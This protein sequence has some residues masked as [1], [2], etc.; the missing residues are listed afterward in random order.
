[1]L[2]REAK[3][4]KGRLQTIT[5]LLDEKTKIL[6]D[7]DEKVL[8]QCDVE[9]IETAIEESEEIISRTLDI[10]RYISEGICSKPFVEPKISNEENL[11]ETNPV[12]HDDQ[13]A[14]LNSVQEQSMISDPENQATVHI[15][16]SP[17]KFDRN[18]RSWFCPSL[19]A[20]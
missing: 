20:M 1:M 14:T 15:N 5:A 3:V 17:V 2:L 9:N 12:L 19:R 8:E 6:K 13:S 18:F 7:L 16:P 10:Q 4:D 11:V